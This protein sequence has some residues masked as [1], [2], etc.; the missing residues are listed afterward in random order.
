[1]AVLVYRP[2]GILPGL[3]EVWNAI[4]DVR[5]V[6][7]DLELENEVVIAWWERYG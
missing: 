5:E 1:M 4:D 6:V 2:A 3:S 7:D